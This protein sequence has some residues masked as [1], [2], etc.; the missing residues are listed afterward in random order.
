[1]LLVKKY[2]RLFLL[3]S[4]LEIFIVH[5]A[6]SNWQNN[7]VLTFNELSA[8]T[9]TTNTSYI[10]FQRDDE[11]GC[12]SPV[13]YDATDPTSVILIAS[14]CG[15]VSKLNSSSKKNKTNFI[16]NRLLDQ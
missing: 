15:G 7:T 5:T 10:Q 16:L 8:I 11:Y 13:G 12:S 14:Y 1:L 9:S 2:R 3:F 6:I 4:F